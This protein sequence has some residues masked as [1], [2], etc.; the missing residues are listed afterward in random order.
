MSEKA[1]QINRKPNRA[2]G[3]TLVLALIVLIPGHLDAK[4][5]PR[6]D[7]VVEAFEKVS[8]AV[9]NINLEYE[10]RKRLNPFPSL[11]TRCSRSFSK[12]FSIQVLIAATSATAWDPA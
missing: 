4:N 3:A 7:A 12:I 1:A 10:V 2:I 5:Y 11:K 9:V 8:P 6:R